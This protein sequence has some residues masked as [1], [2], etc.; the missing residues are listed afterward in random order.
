MKEYLKAGGEMPTPRNPSGIERL[1]PRLN[2]Q[3]LF[4]RF[5][6]EFGGDNS[7]ELTDVIG[8]DLLIDRCL[9]EDSKGNWK[10]MKGNRAPWLL[11]TAVNIKTPDEIWVQ[12]GKQGSI[13]KLY[14]LSRFETGKSGLL[15]CIAVFIRE[16]ESSGLWIG[17]TNFATTR[18]DGYLDSK[19]G[20]G[21][22]KYWRWER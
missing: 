15:S 2:E 21:D 18:D 22:L 19:R 14:Y 10:I 5:M 1:S 8:N 12:N 11:Y 13:D 6:G 4:E 17:R 3:E 16:Q 9:F 7:V 20:I